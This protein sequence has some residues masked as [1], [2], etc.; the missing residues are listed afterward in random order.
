MALTTNLDL[1]IEIDSPKEF[2]FDAKFTREQ[3][4]EIIFIST[5]YNFL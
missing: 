2:I 3:K 1:T 5:I 4:Y